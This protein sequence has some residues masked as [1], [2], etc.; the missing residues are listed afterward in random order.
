MKT[1]MQAFFC[2]LCIH[3]IIF[4]STF[5]WGYIKIKFDKPDILGGYVATG[6]TDMMF[7]F[8][9]SPVASFFVIAIVCGFIII[10]TKKYFKTHGIQ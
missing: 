2:S 7:V 4:M 9:G 8:I 3:I 1:M 10:L 6:H 5:G